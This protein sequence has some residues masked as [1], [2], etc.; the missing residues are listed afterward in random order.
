MTI[1][2][3]FSSHREDLAALDLACQLARSLGTA[4]LAVTVVPA[5]W[6]TAVAGGTDR[7]FEQWA[8]EAG[9][10]ATEAA[11]T[12]LAEH[13][14][15][16]SR[17]TWVHGRSVPSA[18]L[19]EAERAGA[20][21]L[22][23]GSGED[24]P[25]G[26]IGITSKTDR[27]LH[28]STIPIAIATRGYEPGTDATVERVTLGFRGDDATWS[29]LKQVTEVARRVD[30]SLR[31]VTFAVKPHPMYP[32]LVSDTDDMVLGAWV[33]RSRAEHDR[34]R[35]Y[36]AEVGFPAERLSFELPVGRSWGNAMDGVEWGQGD[37]LVVG[38]SSTHRLSRV[39]LGS[40][41]SKII[42]LSPVPVIVEP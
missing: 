4:V 39:F 40:S 16:T 21:M 18:L 36:L 25:H 11:T 7:E 20:G 2:V 32:R 19:A 6:P 12:Y 1:A 23:V 30:A 26:K 42:R 9:A 14:D 27:L 5:V 41:A 15:V 38:S 31:I 34:A 22:V 37:V 29:L 3:G 8:A 33:E 24:V 10:Q 35:D 13:G 17:A 28:S